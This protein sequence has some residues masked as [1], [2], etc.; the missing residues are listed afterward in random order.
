M[1]SFELNVSRVVTSL[2]CDD[3]NILSDDCGVELFITVARLCDIESNPKVDNVCV[4]DIDDKD[5]EGDRR[6]DTTFEAIDIVVSV[7]SSEA[8]AKLVIISVSKLPIS[9][10]KESCIKDVSIPDENIGE[11][12]IERVCCIESKPTN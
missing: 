7:C 6:W 9:V 5:I 11:G 8:V 2:L 10:L 1:S 4:G 3:V 12:S